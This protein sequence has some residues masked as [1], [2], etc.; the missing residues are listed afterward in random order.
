MQTKLLFYGL[1]L[2]FCLSI[3]KLLD[4]SFSIV[5][6][7]TTASIMERLIPLYKACDHFLMFE[8][9]WLGFELQTMDIVEMAIH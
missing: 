9:Y 7:S 8:T 2:T 6:F 5:L 4:R 1:D 3:F